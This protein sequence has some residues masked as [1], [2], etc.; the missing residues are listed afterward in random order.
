MGL[1]R[2]GCQRQP[3]R[4]ARRA[5]RVW[6]RRAV[7]RVSRQREARAGL[8]WRLRA[9]K[10]R[11]RPRFARKRE[12][13]PSPV[14]ASRA[15]SRPRAPQGGGASLTL[16]FFCA[17]CVAAD[18]KRLPLAAA[19]LACSP[20]VERTGGLAGVPPTG[21][22]QGWRGGC[23]QTRIG[24]GPASRASAN[25]H[26]RQWSLRERARARAPRGGRASLPLS[27]FSRPRRRGGPEA[28]AAGS[29]AARHADE[30]M[31]QV[32]KKAGALAGDPPARRGAGPASR[33]RTS[34]PAS[35][36]ACRVAVAF[37]EWAAAHA[38]QGGGASLTL[39]FFR[40]LGVEAGQK[41]L[42][43]AAALFGNPASCL[44]GVEKGGR[45]GG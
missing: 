40:P 26:R 22:A 5:R 20:G 9:N 17:L 3:R 21:S 1:A 23:A 44:P 11:G 42:P 31:G 41:R 34:L 32:S 30:Q 2:S 10:N 8:A 43:L 6:K 39:P 36:A 16:P 37:G 28:A 35:D 19:P 12:H 38:R 18:Q 45:S 14:V 13:A 25:M 4:W 29:R 24:A 7:W 15:G 27:F 33:Q